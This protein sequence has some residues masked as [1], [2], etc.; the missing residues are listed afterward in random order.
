[1]TLPILLVREQWQ[2]FEDAWKEVIDSEGPIDELLVALRLAGEKK[3]ISRCLARAREHALALEASE[4]YADAAHI[5]GAAIVAGAQVS[6]VGTPLRRCAEAAWSKESFWVPFGELT[7]LTDENRDLRKAW[8]DFSTL[9]VLKK[10]Q[11]I[12]HGGGW[13]PGEVTEVHEAELELGI[14]FANGRTDRFPM[15]AAIDIFDPLA[16]TDLR[17]MN[18]RDSADLMK[19]LKKDHLEILRM[20]VERHHGRAGAVAIR[21]ALMQVGIEG[22]AWTAWWRKARKLAENSEWFDV[23][24]SPAKANIRLLL[25][26]KDPIEAL[27]K[28]LRQSN[29]LA[30]MHGR[31]RDLFVSTANVEENVQQVALETLEEAALLDDEPIHQRLAAW[32]FLF[33]RRDAPPEALTKI[34]DELRDAEIPSDP[35]VPPAFWALAQDLTGAKDQERAMRLLPEIYGEGWLDEASRHLQ[36]TP[37]GMV[38]PLIEAL[39]KGK[40]KDDLIEHYAGLLARPLRAPALFVTLAKLLEDGKL[41]E[42]KFPTPVQRAQALL[43]LAHHLFQNRRGNTQT[44]RVHTR[45]VEALAGKEP[46]LRTLLKDVDIAGMRSLQV[47][48]QR[49][50]D[51]TIDHL[52]TDIALDLDRHFFA[53]DDKPFWESETIWTTR[54]GLERRSKELRELREVKIP[55]NQDAIGRAASYG[56]LSENAEWEA[57]MEEMRNLTSR[58]MGIEEELRLADLIENA[59]LREDTACPGTTV[60]Y[61]ELGSKEEKHIQILGPWDEQSEGPEVVSYRAPLAAGMLG[62]QPGEKGTVKLPAGEIQVEVLEIGLSSID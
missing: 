6:E 18:Y 36:H 32:L 27:R 33:E 5:L 48:I 42:S 60:R 28:Q 49:G 54:A 29:D 35:S 1:M 31:V 58:A 44:A 45:L 2:G 41:D 11:L 21:T 62:M 56:D 30:D 23:T 61:R 3:R 8:S 46:L 13:G 55:E 51:D 20:V 50:V 39:R 40:R 43:T 12:F 15:K 34:Y 24:G 14:R 4:R 25:E 26:A 37:P 57:A 52:I 47:Q 9:L 53:S 38:R 22:S 59:V 19:R 17:A 7:G 10:G 16:E